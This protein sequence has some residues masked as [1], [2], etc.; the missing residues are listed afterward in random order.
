MMS[1]GAWEHQIRRRQPRERRIHHRR[2]SVSGGDVGGLPRAQERQIYRQQDSAGALMNAAS[3]Q[4]ESGGSAADGLKNG[5]SASPA[6]F[7]F[8]L[9]YHGEDGGSATS[10]GLGSGRLA[11][12]ASGAAR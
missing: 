6:S 1:A 10:R 12:P 11:R 3:Q 9:H 8:F 5:R 7:P 4:L 2:G